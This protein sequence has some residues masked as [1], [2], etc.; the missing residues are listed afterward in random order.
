[1]FLPLVDRFGDDETLELFSEGSLVEAWL[2]VER[3]LAATQ[4]ELGSH[5][6]GGRRPDRSGR[7]LRQHRPGRAARAD[8]RRRLPDPA[9]ARADRRP[10]AGCCPLHPLGRDHAG[11][12]GHGPRPARGAGVRSDRGAHRRRSASELAAKADTHRA[13]VMAGRTHAQPA[14]PITF[15]GKLAVW[16]AELTRHR[17]RLRAA[18]SP[19]RGRPALRRRRHGGRART[20][21]PQHP[22]RRRREAWDSGRSTCPGTPPATPSPRRASCSRR[23]R[24]PAASSRGR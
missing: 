23:L 7:G 22:P 3:A 10:S 15:G 2:S 19:A 8:A 24:A 9:D 11:H 1:M 13:T 18:A 5:P 20:A 4:A 17:E 12:H 6:A 14:V 21:E 16:L